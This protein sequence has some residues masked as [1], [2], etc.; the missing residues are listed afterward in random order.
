MLE[1]DIILGYTSPVEGEMTWQITIAMF[2]FKNATSTE[3]LPAPG[4]VYRIDSSRPFVYD[5]QFIIKVLEP[6]EQQKLAAEDLDKVKVVPNPYIVTNTMEPAVRN[7]YLNQRRRLM[8]THIPAQCTIKIFTISGY[9]IDE[10][11]VN[12]EPT[13]GIIHWD[14]LTKEDLQIAPGVYVYHLKSHNT[15]KEKMG[16]FAVVK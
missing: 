3:E 4:D 16:K 12:N 6:S 7:V 9:L 5:D 8:F 15:G 13:D 1:D 11:E 14:L 2:N 10:I